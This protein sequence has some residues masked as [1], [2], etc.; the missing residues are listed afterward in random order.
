M[1][2][3]GRSRLCWYGV[4]VLQ[5]GGHS[6]VEPLAV[7]RQLPGGDD[8]CTNDIGSFASDDDEPTAATTTAGD[9][10]ACVRG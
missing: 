10:R 4:S 3:V 5:G 2:S 9:I 6:A 7:V 8:P 1:Q